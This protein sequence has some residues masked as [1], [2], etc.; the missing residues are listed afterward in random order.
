ATDR[1]KALIARE[2]RMPAAL[3]EARKNLSNPPEIYTQIALEQ[4]DGNISFFKNDVVAAFDEVK[5]PALRA[6][7]QKC[8]DAVIAALGGY[9]TFISDTLKPASKGSYAFG[10]DLYRKALS[11]NEMI[12][13]P[14]DRLLDI[15]EQDR[16]KNEAAFRETA[17]K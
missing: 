6:D 12:D 15:A 16:Q 14:L 5:D 10:A 9:K 13:L 4:I 1:L 17:K 3:D 7:F 8:N 2:Q 11:A